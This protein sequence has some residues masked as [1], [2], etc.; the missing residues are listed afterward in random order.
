MKIKKIE[1]YNNLILQERR[2]RVKETILP[3][4][5]ACPRPI[6]V[7]HFRQDMYNAQ[8]SQSILSPFL[9]NENK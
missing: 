9:K 5:R 3:S 4:I 7:V 1:Y 2:M 8:A 6:C